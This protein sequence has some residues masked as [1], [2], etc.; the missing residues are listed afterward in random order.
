[1]IMVYVTYKNQSVKWQTINEKRISNFSKD[2]SKF[3]KNYKFTGKD[4]WSGSS[5]ISD[6]DLYFK[7]AWKKSRIHCYVSHIIQLVCVFQL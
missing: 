1:M 6:T 7:A 2:F 4:I 3:T 5:T